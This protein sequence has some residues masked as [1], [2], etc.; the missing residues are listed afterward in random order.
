M[1]AKGGRCVLAAAAAGGIPNPPGFRILRAAGAG[2]D[3]I[4]AVPTVQ[5]AI[6]WFGRR[7]AAGSPCS[8]WAPAPLFVS[9]RL[10]PAA[11][12]VESKGWGLGSLFGGKETAVPTTAAQRNELLGSKSDVREDTAIGKRTT[13][14]G[15]VN[16]A[17]VKRNELLLKMDQRTEKLAEM[18]DAAAQMADDGAR[19]KNATDDLVNHFKN[20]K[21]W[22]L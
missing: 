22:E 12:A 13:G 8:G 17:E 19:F 11:P 7:A 10:S 5:S 9:G 2:S 3:G 1:P 4:V 18:Q 21:W 20:R 6:R 14:E 15:G 16:M